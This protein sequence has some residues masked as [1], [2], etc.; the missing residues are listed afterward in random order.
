MKVILSRKGTDSSNGDIPSPIFPD[1]TMFSIPIPSGDEPTYSDIAINPDGSLMCSEFLAEINKPGLAVRNCHVDPDLVQRY[2]TE[3]A[4][5]KPAFGQCSAA[6]GYLRNS[7]GVRP[8]D[9]FLFFGNFKAVSAGKALSY[10][11]R[12][13][14]PGATVPEGEIQIIW[15]YLQVGDVLT[16]RHAIEAYSWH[17]HAKQPHIED[18][19]NTL[20][21]PTRKLL[22]CEEMPG[23]GVFNF[24]ERRILTMPGANKATWKDNPVYRPGNIIGNRQNSARGDGIYYAGIWQELCL[25]E[26]AEAEDWAKLMVCGS[27]FTWQEK[28]LL[29]RAAS[30]ADGAGMYSEWPYPEPALFDVFTHIE[31]DRLSEQE[32]AYLRFGAER[33]GHESA[34]DADE[35]AFSVVSSALDRYQTAR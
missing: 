3:Q 22:F 27:F 21:I 33:L 20:Y 5:W 8:G 17:P 13:R 28:Q 6:Q 9:L 23:C 34:A 7:A 14:I 29:R 35:Q 19:N 24:S 16:D 10:R 11:A 4:G 32:I 30:Q 12:P 18:K 2:V 25:A 15:G 26:S 31:D 1:G